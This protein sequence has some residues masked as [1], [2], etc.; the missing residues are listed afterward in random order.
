MSTLADLRARPTVI[1]GAKAERDLDLDAEVCVIGSGA[2]GAIVAATLAE[3]GRAVVVLEEGGFPTHLDFTMR[4][5]DVVPRLYQESALRA[6]AD[7]GISILQGRS[8]GGTTVVN[9]TTSFRTPSDVVDHWRTRHAVGGFTYA[10]LE[11]HYAWIEDRLS[12]QKVPLD[13][14]NRNNQTLYDGCARLGW[15]PDTL[16]RNVHRCLQTGFCHLGCPVN[17]KRSMLVTLV[18]D[19][20]EAGARLVYRAR[21]DKLE[22]KG[23]EIVAAHATLL[24]DDG[25]TPT[26][27]TLRVKARR[28]VTSGGAINSPALLLRSGIDDEG[29]VGARTFLHPVIGNAA[30]FDELVEPFRGAPQS[31]ACHHFAHRGEEVGF[32]LEAAPWYPALAST[33]APGRG[34]AHAAFMQ[35]TRF[36]GLHIA[37]AIDGF[38]DDVPG[39]RVTLRPSG[40]PLVDYPIPDALWRTFRFAQKKLAEL[41]FAAGAREV[42]TL[43]DTPVWMRGH[44]DEAAIDA[45]TW[46]VGSLPVF[47]AHQMGGCRM[48]DDPKDAVVRS[49]DLRHHALTNLY[50]VDGSVFP[51][52]LGVNPQQSIYGLARLAATRLA[53]T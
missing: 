4:E 9:W 42:M 53:E 11:P 7:G 28:F 40:A 18:P 45:A 15:Q 17:A 24:G 35:R 37:L 25:R 36:V 27:R 3:R 44:V 30:L 6:T 12:I 13:G 50:V 31:A 46:R 52:S 33:A 34:A 16:K 21:V 49:Q 39:G 10:E 14:M 5:A 47:T 32:F 26:G 38:H 8:V 1:D 22:R 23:A 43:H 19:A 2:G 51:T 41:A 29:R 48:G 20:L